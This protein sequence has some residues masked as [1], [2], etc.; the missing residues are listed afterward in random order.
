MDES[1]TLL[2]IDDEEQFRFMTKLGLEA[3]GFTVLEA[4]DGNEGLQVLRSAKP[5]LVLLDLNMPK[6]DGHE[7]CDMIKNDDSLRHFPVI[8][9]T[10]SED[11]NDKLQRLDGGADDYVDGLSSIV[12]SG[13]ATVAAAMLGTASSQTLNARASLSS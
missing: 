2:L 1:Y 7:V 5:D 10:T 11:L 3:N 4:A 13:Q 12:T 9:L 8:I 6:P